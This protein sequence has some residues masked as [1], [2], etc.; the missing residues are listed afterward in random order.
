ME[1][2]INRRGRYRDRDRDREIES[3]RDSRRGRDRNWD[4]DSENERDAR[5]DRE[6][7]RRR[8]RDV[9]RDR[10]EDRYTRRERDKVDDKFKKSHR[11]RDGERFRSNG[12][13]SDI[14]EN[15]D[16]DRGWSRSNGRTGDWR[17]DRGR[18]VEE[19]SSRWGIMGVDKSNSTPSINDGSFRDREFR[20]N[21]RTGGTYGPADN[22][23]PAYSGGGGGRGGAPRDESWVEHRLKLRAGARMPVGVWG[24]SPSPPKKRGKTTDADSMVGGRDGAKSTIPNSGEQGGRSDKAKMSEKGRP[25]ENGHVEATSGHSSRTR[26]KRSRSKKS[27]SSS[28]DGDTSSGDSTSD[29]SEDNRKRRDRKRSSKKHRVQHKKKSSVLKKDHEKTK[30]RRPVSSSSSSSS[31][32]SESSDS[33]PEVPAQSIEPAPHIL[34]ELDAAEAAQFKV[35]VQGHRHHQAEDSDED[36]AGPKPVPQLD[37]LQGEGA[38]G[39]NYGGALLPGEGAAIAQFV[40][41]GMRIPRRGEVGWAGQEIEKLEDS[42]YVMSGSRHARMN[43]V[44]L[45]KENQVFNAEERRALAL[46]MFE[47]KQQKENEI[48]GNFRKMLTEA[49]EEDKAGENI[50]ERGKAAAIGAQG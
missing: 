23:R 44:R 17:M 38:H 42:G 45:R 22:G 20:P 8:E 46:I 49:T 33:N 26:S 24:R 10:N 43:A 30:K 1:R 40:Q 48:L 7:E 4:R 28:N 29:S 2:E 9:D 27:S 18:T 3:V 34:D 25:S 16:E 15:M 12:D 35:D 31:S 50:D 36:D 6:K 32:S 41:K 14:E 47:E 5:R 11:G 19:R 37:D 21:E 13:H 39:V